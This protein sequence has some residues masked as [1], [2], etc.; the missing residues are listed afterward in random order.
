ME[1]NGVLRE[2]EK[3]ANLVVAKVM[4]VTFLMF[5]LI[6]ILNVIGIFVVDSFIMTVAFIGGSALLLL[7]TLLVNILKKDQPYVKFVNVI[8]SVVFVTLLSITL[9]FHVVVIYVYPI[10]IASLYFS[11]KLNII[12]TALT[13]VGVSVGQVLAFN[14][15]TLIDKNFDVMND[16]LIYGVV[17][18]ALV[19]VAVA[20]IF[21]MLCSRT[22]SMLSNL[23]GA[24]E[25]KRVLDHMNRMQENAAETS[26][27]LFNMVNELAGITN[28]SLSANQ[29]IVEE[30]ENLLKGSVENTDAVENADEKIADIAN[31]LLELSSMNEKMAQL[32]DYIGE[33]ISENQSRMDE[34]TLGMEQ[35][36]NSTDQCKE[37]ISNLGEQTKEIIG[38]TQTITGISNRTNILALNATIE[39]ARAGEQ[40]KGF[41][42]VAEEIQKLSEQT[43]TAVES[44]GAI[45]RQVVENTESAVQAMEQNV[46]YTQKGMEDIR[47]AN[48]SSMLITTS[49]E[50]LVEQVHAV[51]KVAHIIKEKS[52]EMSNNMK[53]ISNNTQMNCDAV[54]HV[55]AASQENSA[56][57]ESLAEIVE[58]I[59]GISEQLNKVVQG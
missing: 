52:D 25:Q 19:L 27:V 12:A 41:A 20:A 17:P 36:S 2:N 16:V 5:I 47:K 40:G 32:T 14:M 35:I 57:V 58:Q 48:E 18:R 42:V 53:Q 51:D 34:A 45:V 22:A 24:E 44:I 46:Q 38:I 23:M 13:V 54:E 11:K 55:T 33:N 50:Q 30:A 15:Q 10:A 31:Q 4:R 59:K 8:C 3:Q 7:P 29:K 39:A 37:I 26:D 1:N 43:K 49:N 28:N 21:T 9:T 56:G 6:Y